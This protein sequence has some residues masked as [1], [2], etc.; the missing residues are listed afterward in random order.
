M[1]TTN[2]NYLFQD[3]IINYAHLIGIDNM[4][5]GEFLEK[6]K[7]NYSLDTPQNN[8]FYIACEK[9]EFETIKLNNSQ[10]TILFN[11]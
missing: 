8:L 9:S 5:K 2:L 11:H 1:K 6:I 7:N 10:D 4:T 3:L